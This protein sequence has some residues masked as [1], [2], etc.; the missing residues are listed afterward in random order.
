MRSHRSNG[1]PVCGHVH[2]SRDCNPNVLRG[3]DGAH[4]R[5]WNQELDPRQTPQERRTLARRLREGFEMMQDD[6]VEW[7]Q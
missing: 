2:I 4:T 7:D 6:D 3:I 1:C 5:A